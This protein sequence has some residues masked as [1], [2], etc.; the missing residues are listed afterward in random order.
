[1][2]AVVMSISESLAID[3]QLEIPVTAG[4]IGLAL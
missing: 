3:E 1:M 2:P 4:L